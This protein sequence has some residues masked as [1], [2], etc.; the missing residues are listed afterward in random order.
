[1][2]IAHQWSRL[3]AI[4]IVLA[5]PI[6]FGT[7]FTAASA[8]VGHTLTWLAAGDSYASGA[9]LT[10]TTHLCARATGPSKAWAS[11][12]ESD[13]SGAGFG[14]APPNFVACSGATQQEFFYSL[15]SGSPAEWTKSMG[16][17]DLVTFSFGGDDVRF[18]SIV[19]ACLERSGGCS[20][21][22]VRATIQTIGIDYWAF[23]DRVAYRAVVHDGNIVV[24]GY[25]ELVED[26]SLWWATNRLSHVCQGFTV[27]DSKLIR[28]WAGDLNAWLGKAV[29]QANASPA[30]QRNGVEFTFVDP[31]TGQSGNEIGASDA[32]LF[33]PATGTRH[34]LCSQ[35]DSAWLNGLAPLH[36]L[37]RSFHPSQA[38]ENAMGNLAA[39]VIGRLKWSWSPALGVLFRS[40]ATGFG[41]VQPTTVQYGG[42]G[43]ARAK[44]IEWQSWGG[45][46]AIG[47][48]TGWYVP[49]GDAR[50]QGMS[51]PITVVAFDL[52]SCAGSPAYQAFSWYFASE[53][54]TFDPSYYVDAC[55]EQL[56]NPAIPSSP[57]PPPPTPSNSGS[58]A[59][60][61]VAALAAAATQW[62]S[63]T[64]DPDG[65]GSMIL[66]NVCVDNYAAVVFT[67]GNDP[68]TAATMAFV[69]GGNTWQVL[70]EGNILPTNIG[71]PSDVY[72]QLQEAS[73]NAPQDEN[74]PF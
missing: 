35:G 52:G 66:S 24:M 27:N 11:V 49:D 9:G 59:N 23:L 21:S 64:G 2:R 36:L 19:E 44:D 16:R 61:D 26:P 1:M 68:G 73:V 7:G 13:L 14:V 38:G 54:E 3:A 8:A 15:G 63:S 62:E 72:T 71:L 39:E 42:D 53:A 22:E 6:L 32:N 58:S 18:S 37:T 25:P 57:T 69:F 12:A 47:T 51:A 50:Y 65:T 56:V 29:A 67:P 34:E 46:Q 41:S 20:D 31:V 10:H 74:V 55:T 40:E 45:T 33:E 28:G 70:G 5:G 43:Y 48:G 4:V 30:K 60:C 17:Y